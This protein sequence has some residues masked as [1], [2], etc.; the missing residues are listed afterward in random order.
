MQSAYHNLPM[1]D[2]VQQAPGEEFAAHDVRYVA[3]NDQAELVLDV[4]GAYPPEA[5]LKRWLRTIRLNRGQSVTVEDAYELDHTP[6]NLLLNLLT[7]CAV[8]LDTVGVIRLSAADLPDGRCAGSGVIRYD[9]KHFAP[10]VE[11]I[12]I[13]D[14]RMSKVWGDQLWRILLTANNPQQQDTWKLEIREA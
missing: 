1:I 14:E 7:V 4:A 3:T 8:S 2:G 10:S 6:K 13:T 5:G 11:T 12:P 9:A